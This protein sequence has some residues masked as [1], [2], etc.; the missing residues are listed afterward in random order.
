MP[1]RDMGTRQGVHLASDMEKQA[2]PAST[3]RRARIAPESKSISMRKSVHLLCEHV[4]AFDPQG[5]V[6][7]N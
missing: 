5:V 2:S 4:L 3:T 6:Y 7:T 1:K